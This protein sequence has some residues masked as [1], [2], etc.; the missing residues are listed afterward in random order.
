[1]KLKI[2]TIRVVIEEEIVEEKD[3]LNFVT[4]KNADKKIQNISIVNE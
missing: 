1:M 2:E 4:S 3:F